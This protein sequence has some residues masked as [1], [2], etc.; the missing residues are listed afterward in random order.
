MFTRIHS[1]IIGASH[2]AGLVVLPASRGHALHGTPCTLAVSPNFRVCIPRAGYAVALSRPV[3]FLFSRASVLPSCS[4][5]RLCICPSICTNLCLYFANHWAESDLDL[6]RIVPEPFSGWASKTACIRTWPA[7]PALPLQACEFSPA[8]LSAAHL[9]TDSLL[10]LVSVAGRAVSTTKPSLA[11]A[12]A[13]TNSDSKS[14]DPNRHVLAALV[15]NE[16]GVLARVVTLF[17]GRGFNID[18]LCVTNPTTRCL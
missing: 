14:D 11:K 8:Q 1:R 3:W 15:C 17:S 18:S 7:A 12:Q 2:V 4:P 6:P 9:W 13:G 5:S 10:S 16:A